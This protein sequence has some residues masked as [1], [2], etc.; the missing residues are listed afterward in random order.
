MGGDDAV[1]ASPGQGG[2][3]QA[4][5][6]NSGGFHI[7]TPGRS[8]RTVTHPESGAGGKATAE[9]TTQGANADKATEHGRRPTAD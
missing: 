2:I 1:R 9:T 8:Q 6:M 3:R 7:D 4:K 5:E